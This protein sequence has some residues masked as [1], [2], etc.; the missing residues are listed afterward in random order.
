MGKRVLLFVSPFATR[1][2]G[3]RLPSRRKK[4]DLGS[5]LAAP[6]PPWYKGGGFRD[7]MEAY[8]APLES[9]SD[10]GALPRRKFTLTSVEQIFYSL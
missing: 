7:A 1:R 10:K 2:C 4:K 8:Q 6:L 9:V 3:I 5:R